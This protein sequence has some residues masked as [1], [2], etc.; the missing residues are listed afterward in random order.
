LKK[1]TKIAQQLGKNKL[2]KFSQLETFQRVFQPE[3]DEVLNK[4]YHLK[5]RWAAA[6]FNNANPIVLEL[7][8]GK[9]EYTVNQ[10]VLNSNKNYIGIDIKGSRIWHGAKNANDEE[11]VNVGFLRTRIEL[12]ESFFA[13]NEVEQIW[14]TFPDPQLKRKRNKKRLTGSSFLNR[15]RTF[16]RDNGVIHL[17][18]DNDVLYSYTLD[19]ARHNKLE[20][21]DETNDLYKSSILNETLSIKT[22]YENQ[23]LE[24]GMNINYIS[25][26]IPRDQVICEPYE[27]QD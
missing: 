9:G 11:L 6:V 26:K 25:F 5:G 22:Y 23:F 18:T 4:D 1:L 7:G 17:K 2:R 3:I 19:I 14:I 20:I 8:C 21:I 16:L 27:E 12:I 13:Q 10:A 24:K 15:Y